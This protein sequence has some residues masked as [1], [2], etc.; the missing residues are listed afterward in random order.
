[1][2]DNADRAD[3]Q[4]AAKRARGEALVRAWEE[5]DR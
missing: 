1:M 2:G 5:E 4:Y 3:A